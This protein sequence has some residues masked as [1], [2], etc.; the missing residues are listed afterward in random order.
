M[1]LTGAEPQDYRL[2]PRQK[3]KRTLQ[4]RNSGAS[5]S[6]ETHNYFSVLSDSDVDTESTESTP[7]MTD[8]KNRIPPVVIYSYLNNHTQILKQ[9]H[10]KMTSPIEIKAKQNKLVLYAKTESDYELLLREIQ[11]AKIA[12]HTYQLPH[13]KQPRVTLKGLPPNIPTEEIRAELQQLKLQVNNIRQIVRKD[14]DSDNKRPIQ[15]CFR[16]QQ[17]GHASMYCGRP[18]KCVKCDLQHATQE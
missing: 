4:H 17:Y 10:E 2:Q 8:K 16:C 7:P 5:T 6:I 11:Q 1:N 14:K 12:Y 9:L 15:Q 13:L 18:A 3:R